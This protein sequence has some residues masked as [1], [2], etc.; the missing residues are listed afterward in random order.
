MA[1]RR[2]PAFTLVELML[3]LAMVL[4]LIIGINYV[5]RSRQRCRRRRR[6]SQRDQQRAQATQPILFNDLRDVSK[7]P[8]C[9]I[10][11]SQLVTQFLNSDDAKTSSD[12]TVIVTDNAGTQVKIANRASIG[13]GPGKYA[14]LFVPR[15][16]QQS[17][18]SRRSA[19]IL[20]PRPVPPPLRQRR[21]LLRHGI[22]G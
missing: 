9:F 1:I 11:A 15:D 22:L 19:E 7:N 21:H 4:L 16:S 6:K 2:I 17:E 3:S 20:C 10:I 5:F 12:P 18:S 13:V 14:S 8:P